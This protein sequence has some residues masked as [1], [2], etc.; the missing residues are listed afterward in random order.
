MSLFD[1]SC[2]KDTEDHV[3]AGVGGQS[4]VKKKIFYFCSSTF[5][6]VKQSK[7]YVPHYQFLL[8][9]VES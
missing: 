8:H 7:L 4:Y 6:K 1:T 5:K 3:T 2:Q 9:Q